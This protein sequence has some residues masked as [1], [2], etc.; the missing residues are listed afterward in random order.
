MYY[1]FVLAYPNSVNIIRPNAGKG[2]ELRGV[3]LPSCL[4]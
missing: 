2:F 4:V 3:S 1:C